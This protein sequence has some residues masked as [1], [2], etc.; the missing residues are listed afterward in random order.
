MLLVSGRASDWE[1]SRGVSVD[2]KA[3][4]GSNSVKGGN[5]KEGIDLR[6]RMGTRM[7]GVNDR[8][9]YLDWYFQRYIDKS[10]DLIVSYDRQNE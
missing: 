10:G 6:W 5:A 1:S 3:G 4:E 9:T 2:E 8:G 7:S